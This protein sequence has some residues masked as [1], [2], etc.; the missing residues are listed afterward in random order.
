MLDRKTYDGL[1]ER[2]LLEHL[3]G[4]SSPDVNP[5]PRSYHRDHESRHRSEKSAEPPA[6]ASSDERASETE[7]LCHAGSPDIE[8]TA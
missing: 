3:R 1:P 4:D 5:R 7:Y 6:N 2:N 8:S